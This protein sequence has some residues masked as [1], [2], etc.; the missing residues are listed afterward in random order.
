MTVKNDSSVEATI[1]RVT[2]DAGG[3]RVPSL[4]R[5]LLGRPSMG[6]VAILFVLVAVFSLM[7]PEAFLGAYNFRS[8]ALAASVVGVM[9]IGQTFVLATGGIDLSVGSVLVFGTVVSAK[10]MDALGGASAGWGAVLAGT[11]VCVLAT[12]FWGLVNGL[13]VAVLRVPPLIATLGTLGMALGAA[14]IVSNGLDIRSVPQVLSHD[15]GYENVAGIPLLVVIGLVVA[16]VAGL[17]MWQTGFGVHTK[18][19]GSNPE[20]AVRSGLAVR[21]HLVAVYT[22]TGALAGVAGMMSLAQ[23]STTTIGG[24]TADNLTTIA[25]AVLGGT[26]LFGGIATMFGT[27]IGI[28]VPVTLSAGFVIVGVQPFWQTFA[29]GAVLVAAVYVDQVRRGA[30]NRR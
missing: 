28:L 13:I 27:V 25:G 24:H 19:I 20:G 29:V 30:Q 3:A 5:R 9:A 22:L 17:V 6:M 7:R 1:A 15:V 16:A 12:A 14:Q 23:F 11:A 4:A 10:T 26:S 18:A 2:G 8:I 21:K